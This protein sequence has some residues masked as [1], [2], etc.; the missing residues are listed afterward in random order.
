MSQIT[1]EQAKALGYRETRIKQF[2]AN[3]TNMKD[4][5]LAV[6][7]EFT[8]NLPVKQAK[9]KL[10]E[11]YKEHSITRPAK[12]TDIVALLPDYFEVKLIRENGKVNQQLIRKK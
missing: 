12:T 3:N 6:L 9:A 7:K 10:A 8:S 1:P 5:K 4:I 2:I 11:I